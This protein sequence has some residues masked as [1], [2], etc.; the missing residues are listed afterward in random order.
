MQHHDP[1]VWMGNFFNIDTKA[2]LRKKPFRHLN[3]IGTSSGP[4]YR[5]RHLI[6]YSQQHDS[7]AFVCK[8]DA[9]FQQFV[10]VNLYFG[11]FEFNALV[12]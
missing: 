7:A 5:A 8:G 9:V 2:E 3:N 6:G 1:A 11:F 4:N 10:V 12:L